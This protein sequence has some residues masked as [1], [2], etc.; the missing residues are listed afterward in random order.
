MEISATLDIFLDVVFLMDIL[1]NFFAGYYDLGGTR[2]PVIELKSVMAEYSRSW[3]AA[4]FST[5]RTTTRRR[6]AAFADP[7]THTHTHT[8]TH[9][10]SLSH[11]HTPPSAPLLRAAGSYSTCSPASPSTVS[12][13]RSARCSSSRPSG[14]SRCGAS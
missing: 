3:C 7:H 5:F 14:C 2:F 6:R 12:S 1:I 13:R 4:A 11:T 8:H 10:L 9:S